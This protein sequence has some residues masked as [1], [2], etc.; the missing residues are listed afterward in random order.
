M[1]RTFI[2]M[3]AVLFAVSFSAPFEAEY[4]PVRQPRY[5]IFGQSKWVDSTLANMTLEQKIGQLFM[6]AAWS[7]PDKRNMRELDRLVRENHIGGV[8]FFKG[9]PHEQAKMTNTLQAKSRIPL[10]VGIDGEWGLAMR[11]DS[12]I[13][14]GYQMGLGAAA[15][16]SLVYR[17]AKEIALECKRL[18]IHINFAPVIDINNNPLNPV[19]HMRSFGEDKKDV[20]NKALMYMRGMQDQRVLAVAK[21]FPGHG[22]TNVD[23]HHDLPV[24]YQS[25]AELDTLELY[26]FK[27]LFL[28]GVGGVMTAHL[29]IPAYD[30]TP[31]L[32]A[33]L[34]PVITTGLL[35]NKMNFKG[36][37]FSD[38]LNMKGVAKYYKPGEV[39]LAAL[40][41]GNDVLLYAEDVPRAAALIKMAVDS[42]CISKAFIDEKVKRILQVKYWTGLSDC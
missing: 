27:H 37:T 1:I 23:S 34:S 5:N 20:T 14:Y 9:T 4:S 15:D 19:I 2:L 40:L 36:L 7:S 42:G 18:G 29:H 22:N 10:L 39:E 12:T 35:R 11:L 38:A 26:P 16:D 3:L 24:L 13:N 25:K 33:S 30:S 17:M 32:G 6:V 28:Q 8:I 41:A 21:H 31:N